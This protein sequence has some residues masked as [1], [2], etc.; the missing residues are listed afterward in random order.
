MRIA[1]FVPLV[2]AAG[3][4]ACAPT[5]VAK[6]E[7]PKVT[8]TS[9]GKTADGTEVSLF[10]LKNSKGMEAAVT[11][12]GGIV[13]SLK[14][15]D[16]TGAIGD[17][18]LGFDSLDGYLKEHPYLGA[19][20]GRY[21]NRIG[22]AKFSIGGKQYKLAVNNGPNSLHGGLRG[23]DKKVWD[24][25]T[26]DATNS[27]IL[28]CSSADMEEGYPGKLD[29]EVTYTLTEANELR[30]N[31]K[32]ATDKETVLN[33]TNHTYF[34]L[35]GQGNGDI[36]NHSIQ[37]MS[38]RTTPVDATLIPTGELKQ[39]AG[40]PFDFTAPHKIGERINDPKDEQIK[41]GGGYDHNFVVDGQPGTLRPAARVTE[42]ASGRA[43]EVL[44]TE[45]GIQ[46]YTGNFLDGALT[47]K[48]GKVYQKR[49]G[50]CLETQHFPDSP[51]KPQFPTT[52]LKPGETYNS[53]TVFRFSVAQ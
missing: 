42:P 17:I 43:M 13:V 51:N 35:A 20:V 11:N 38:E 19:I 45:P 32:A 18:V 12:Y 27:L 46:F 52:A 9:F 30:I 2:V 37:I 24:A 36:L 26:N 16:K 44:T 8:K 47:G 48:G 3:L 10:T 22:G 39:V 5:P 25:T 28:K 53:T 1:V 31:Y 7:A 15:P 40:T 33:L 34:N 14:T 6:K 50:F 21:G 49:Y 23:F 4:V 29:A 41:F